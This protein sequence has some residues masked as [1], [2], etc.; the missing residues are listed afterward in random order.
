MAYGIKYECQWTSP[1]REQREYVIRILERDY[2]GSVLPL[3]PCGDVLTITQGQID[4]DELQPIKASE[5]QLS[6]LCIEGDDYLS[7]FTTDPLRYRLLVIRRIRQPIIV[8]D[9]VEWEG[10]LAAGVYAQDYDNP[11]YHVSLS[12][13]DG[14]SLLKDIPYLN[15]DKARYKGMRTVGEMI[16][17][18]I[19]RISERQVLFPWQMAP[20]TPE[21]P[22]HSLNLLALESEAVYASFGDE[23]PSCYNVLEATLH[24]LGLQL[25]QS[26]G[27]WTVRQL[28]SLATTTRAKGVSYINNGYVIMPLYTDAGN[29]TGVS[30][31][32]TLS[33]LPPYRSAAVE[34]PGANDA[35]FEIPSILDQNRWLK[36]ANTMSKGWFKRGDMLRLQA[37]TPANTGK[38]G[39]YSG[40]VYVGDSILEPATTTAISV[41]IDCYNL[42]NTV[43]NICAGLFL[44]DADASNPLSWLTPTGDGDNAIIVDSIVA[45]WNNSTSSWV[46]LKPDSDETKK[47]MHEDLAPYM[48]AFALDA[49]RRYIYFDHPAKESQMTL[50]GL[51]LSADTITNIAPK[52]RLIIVLT[53]AIDK[54]LQ[55]IELRKPT[56]TFEQKSEI[57]VEYPSPDETVSVQGLGSI[58]YKQHFADVWLLNERAFQAP[59]VDIKNNCVLRG[60]VAPALRTT[61]ADD[62]VANIRTLRGQ[63]A[64]QIEGEIYATT[65]LDLD[66]MWR[67]REGRTYYTN[68][69]RRHLKRGLYTVQLR[70]IPDMVTTRTS[71]VVF[72]GEMTNVVGLDTSAY[73]LSA[74]GRNLWRYDAISDSTAQILTSPNGSYAITLNEGQRAVSVITFDGIYYG[75]RAFD[76]NGELLSHIKRLN[77][78]TNVIFPSII[79]GFARSARYDANTNTWV[80]VGGDSSVT[81]LQ[82][83]SRDGESYGTTI[84][85]LGNYIG[86]KDSVLIPNGFTYTSKPSTSGS[87]IYAWWHSNAQHLDATVEQIGSNLRV[88]ACN[89]MF[90][91]IENLALGRIGLHPRTDTR[92]GYDA[93]LVEFS[94]SQVV[95]VGMNNALALFRQ[96][97]TSGALAYGAMI[98]DARTGNIIS[99]SAPMSLATTQL[100][101]SQNRVYGAWVDANEAYHILS[102]PIIVGDGSPKREFTVSTELNT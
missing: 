35:S 64:R 81:Y 59:F 89:E 11:P 77:D 17:D 102:Q 48:Q 76:T 4:A 101:I 30:T 61:L 84:Y 37:F 80:L 42:A 3:Y 66:A 46:K 12:A 6:L 65:M 60:L 49:S 73:W 62:V 94:T 70:E 34:R 21:Q 56:I 16:A 27:T 5:A 9:V 33:L 36:F 93:A 14:L 75:L 2:A 57:I 86:V 41:D 82:M 44:V 83:L 26:Y 99:L 40:L 54:P 18:I 72:N 100:W 8:K 92:I 87:N 63:I 31:S 68:Y 23:T 97:S 19:G 13:V 7:L 67:D 52:M 69:V 20:I 55:N 71:N 95:F 28:A 22:E 51:S 50:T 15:E 78:I 43:N 96:I 85:S 24:S 25:F 91:V 32:A 1:M 47:V 38:G 45:G 29:D 88:L 39:R 53:G 98:Y 74:N 90:I 79:D 10:Y 58:T